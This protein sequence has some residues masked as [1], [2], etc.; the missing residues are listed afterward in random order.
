MNISG[1]IGD[2]F[3]HANNF[4]K[5][6]VL[7]AAYNGEKWIVEQL[8]SILAQKNVEVTI[9]ISLDSS[10]DESHNLISKFAS[11]KENII[12]LPYGNK[13]GSASANFFRLMADVDCYEFS[14]VALADQ[15][16]IWFP[17]K[18]HR[19]W[20]KL[21][22]SYYHAY[23]SNVLAVWESG[24]KK[25]INKS[26]EQKKMDYFFESAG[27]GC[28]YVLNKKEFLEFQ[29]FISKNKN[30]LNEVVSHDWLIY[31]YYR[32]RGF[33][34]FI[35]PVP[36]MLYRQHDA[37]QVGANDGVRAYIKRLKMIRSHWF[38]KQV[39]IITKLINPEKINDISK[40]YFLIKNFIQLRR[41]K[42][43][44]ILLLFVIL[45]GIY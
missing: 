4:P 34:W 15:D 9:F 13:F 16:D 40:K 29:N 18:L 6:A 1:K 45:F 37:N 11:K 19:A 44:A 32:E 12:F 3:R 25:L 38:R 23:S 7:L 24:R 22:S 2:A 27:P 17:D 35:D 21:K 33:A 28:T 42:R 10:N 39:L 41:K 14:A 20:V 5:I 43:E 26:Q 8:N 36:T 30:N 31:A